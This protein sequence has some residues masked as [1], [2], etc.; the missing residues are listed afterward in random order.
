VLAVFEHETP[1]RVPCW[2]GASVEFWAKAKRQLGLDDEGLR[3]R[4]HD[5]FRWVRSQYVGPS[6]RL[7]EGCT[8]RTVFGVERS[9]LGY[10]QPS[11]HPLAGATVA[12]VHDYAWPDPAWMDVSK[13][14]SQARSYKG[15]YAIL[16]GE[17]SPFWHD[18]IDLMGMEN[19]YIQMYSE[20]EV[21][22]AV[23]QYLVDFYFQASKRIFDA[24]G[25]EIDIFFIGNDFGSQNGPL[26][27]PDLFRKFM[28]P[29]LQRLADLG[30]SYGMKVQMHCC[31]GI[32]E[33]IPLMIEAGL[34]GLHAVQPDCQ[35]MDLA[36]I[37]AD[38]GDRIV[39]NGGIDSKTILIDGTVD[40]VRQKTLEVLNTMMPGGGYIAGASHDTILGETPIENVSAMFDTVEESG[41]Y[42]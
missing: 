35:G 19:L 22:E 10:G 37:K 30:H 5:D 39:L 21:V 7:S 40:Y 9:G 42:C 29:H 25:N 41:R 16:G 31:G 28:F 33:L 17:W 20:P 26:M 11:S 15:R 34:D 27:S 23:L 38:F 6:H 18:A 24:A 36:R 13:I 12:Q 3:V 8:Q 4:W 32:F 14:R 1:D 2:C